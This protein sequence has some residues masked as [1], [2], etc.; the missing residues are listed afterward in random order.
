M[1]STVDSMHSSCGRIDEAFI[2]L[3][4]QYPG[5]GMSTPGETDAAMAIYMHNRAVKRRECMHMHSKR[6]TS[7]KGQGGRKEVEERRSLFRLL[8]DE[9]GIAG[10]V[11]GVP[12]RRPIKW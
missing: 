12:L 11:H 1:Y 2:A 7:K 3:F 5:L 4:G 8:S 10:P 9:Q 6:H